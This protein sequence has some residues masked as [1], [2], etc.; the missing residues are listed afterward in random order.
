M[1]VVCASGFDNGLQVEV[2][3]TGWEAG[4][5]DDQASAG[6]LGCCFTSP[7]TQGAHAYISGGFLAVNGIHDNSLDGF[8]G[9]G[10]A[11]IRI[12]DDGVLMALGVQRLFFA[13]ESP[14]LF[15]AQFGV[16]F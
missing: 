16:S 3:V 5:D 12:L 9:Y 15:L 13:G 14:D 8:G 2:G 1:D 7:D 11:G 4:L 6:R 10:E